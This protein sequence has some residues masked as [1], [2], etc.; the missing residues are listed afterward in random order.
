MGFR[1]F[2]GFFFLFSFFVSFFFKKKKGNILLFLIPLLSNSG[3][4]IAFLV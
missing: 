3:V 4:L 2:D 1:F